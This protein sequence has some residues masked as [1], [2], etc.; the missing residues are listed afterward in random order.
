MFAFNSITKFP[1]I[2]T[3]CN[4]KIFFVLKV[5]L[6]FCSLYCYSLCFLKLHKQYFNKIA[7]CHGGR[8]EGVNIWLFK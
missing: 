1:V 2:V 6:Y 3:K 5:Y 7:S 4:N 8:V